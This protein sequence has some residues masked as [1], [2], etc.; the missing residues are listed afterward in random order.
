MEGKER[1]YDVILKRNERKYENEIL[2][3]KEDEI[4]SERRTDRIEQNETKAME[5]SK[6]KDIKKQCLSA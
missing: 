2:E 3:R 1:K 5:I 4:F 6:R